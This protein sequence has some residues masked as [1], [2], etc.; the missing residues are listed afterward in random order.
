MEALF[1]GMSIGGVPAWVFLGIGMV[2]GAAI[3]EASRRQGQVIK[4]LRKDLKETAT[5]VAELKTAMAV[6]EERHRVERAQDSS[7][8]S[9]LQSEIIALRLYIATLRGI[10]ADK[11]I[12]SPEPP[13]GVTLTEIEAVPDLS[14]GP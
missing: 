13:A 3:I 2:L 5:A 14:G 11:G 9:R 8:I 7:L 6:Q 4:E 1:D 12:S 10:L